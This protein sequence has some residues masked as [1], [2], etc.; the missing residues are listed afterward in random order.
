MTNTNKY[1]RRS[2]VMSLKDESHRAAFLFSN[3]EISDKKSNFGNFT[4][5]LCLAG[6]GVDVIVGHKFK[7]EGAGC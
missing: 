6:Q 4:Q 5:R 7:Q 2:G 3:N 1:K